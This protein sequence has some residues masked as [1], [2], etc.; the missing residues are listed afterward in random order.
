MLQG[1][2]VEVSTSAALLVRGR[3]QPSLPHALQVEG[4]TQL[5]A[6]A[7]HVL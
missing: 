7:P 4:M 5:A 2:D 3:A 6:Q 1:P